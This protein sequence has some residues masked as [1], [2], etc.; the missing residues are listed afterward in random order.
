MGVM[1]HHAIIVSSWKKDLLER[2]HLQAEMLMG[3]LVTPIVTTEHNGVGSFAV[4]PDGSK[5]GWGPSD[6]GDGQRAALDKWLRSHAYEDGSNALEWVEVAFGE[7]RWA[8]NDAE[9]VRH[10]YKPSPRTRQWLSPCS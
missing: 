4:L 8:K 5:E 7:L 9:V 3:R 2:A 10:G 6:L 1:V